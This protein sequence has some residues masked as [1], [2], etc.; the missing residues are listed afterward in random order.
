MLYKAPIHSKKARNGWGAPYFRTSGPVHSAKISREIS[1]KITPAIY[2]CI[3]AQ[4]RSPIGGKVSNSLRARSA[5]RLD[6]CGCS[7]ARM[8]AICHTP[9]AYHSLLPKRLPHPLPGRF[10][11]LRQNARFSDR[12]HEVSVPQPAWHGVQMQMTSHPRARRAS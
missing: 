12:R 7:G 3:K 10:Q 8:N 4:N 9:I 6:C 5:L 1:S 2:L 11:S